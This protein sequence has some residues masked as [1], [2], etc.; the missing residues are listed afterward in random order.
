MFIGKD[1][2]QDI[3][4]LEFLLEVH[5]LVGILNG[6]FKSFNGFKNE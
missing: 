3:N 1:V 4:S 6:L 2:L 5:L